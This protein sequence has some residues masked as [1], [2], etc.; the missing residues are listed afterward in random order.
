MACVDTSLAQHI[1]NKIRYIQW[2]AGC[3]KEHAHTHIHSLDMF[4]MSNSKSQDAQYLHHTVCLTKYLGMYK[5][6]IFD[7][8]S[9]VDVICQGVSSNYGKVYI[10]LLP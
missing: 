4:L 10:M 1:W 6:L 5:P 8:T 7:K 9:L 2:L 3:K